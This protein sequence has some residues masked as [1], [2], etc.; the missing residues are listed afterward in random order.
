[1]PE[2]TPL[3]G[4]RAPCRARQVVEMEPGNV[5]AAG[6][7]IKARE[8][9]QMVLNVERVSDPNWMHKPEPEKTPL[10]KRTEGAAALNDTKMK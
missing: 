1:M 3:C 7:L 2:P 6:R 4:P 10:Q 5:E 9:L 8:M